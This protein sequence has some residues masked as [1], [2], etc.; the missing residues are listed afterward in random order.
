[1]QIHEIVRSVFLI[2]QHVFSVNVARESKDY[3]FIL[4]AIPGA[5]SPR[6]DE[7]F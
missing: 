4:L 3:L 5:Q 1:M 7:D 2:A 6:E